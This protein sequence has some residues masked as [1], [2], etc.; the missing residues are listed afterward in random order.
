[1]KVLLVSSE[2]PPYGSGIANAVRSIQAH[3]LRIGTEVNVLSSG[4]ADI[5]MNSTLNSVPGIFGLISFWER[6]AHYLA[7]R[8]DEYDVVWLHSPLLIDARKLRRVGKIMITIHTTYYGFYQAYKK[9]AICHLLPYYFAAAKLENQF[10]KEISLLSNTSVTAVSPSV[11]EEAKNNGLT[12]LPEFVPNGLQTNPLAGL[13]EYDERLILN[14]E[15]GLQFG[16][17]EKTLVYVGRLTEQKQPLLLLD[18]FKVLSAIRPATQLIIVGTGNLLTKTRKKA[19]EL[20]KAHVLGRIPRRAVLSLLSQASMYISLSCYEGLPLAALEAASFGLPMILSDI[21]AHRWIINS[22]IGYGRTL[23][24]Y[25]PNFTEVLQF[26]EGC[27]PTSR[28]FHKRLLGE[29]TWNKIIGQ[30]LTLWNK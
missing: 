5:S 14:K 13:N 1:M 24:S 9:H 27:V 8:V 15:Y 10:F 16:E 30:Y 12:Y 17:E 11:A 29:Y 23:N 19:A 26:I 22:G 18:F 28:K 2:F 6:A 20:A 21:P 25:K 4:W 7:K 3:M